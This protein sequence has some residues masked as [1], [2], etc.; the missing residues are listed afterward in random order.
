M[1]KLFHNSLFSFFL[2]II[3]ASVGIVSATVTILSYQVTYEPNDNEWNVNT[4]EDA[5]DD[6]YTK[7]SVISGNIYYLGEGT[8]FDLKTIIPSV[9]YTKLTADNFIVEAQSKASTTIGGFTSGGPSSDFIQGST[10][11]NKS[12]NASTGV[13]SAHYNVYAIGHL[14]TGDKAWYTKAINWNL[15]VKAYVIVNE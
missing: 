2:G 10:T 4:V 8:S 13:L 5:L 7:A 15:N 11:L 6:L 14:Y 1:K 12:Y 3:V 9:D